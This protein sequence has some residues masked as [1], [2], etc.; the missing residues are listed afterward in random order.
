MKS[1]PNCITISRIFFSFLILF[2]RPL[3]TAFYLLY[4]ICGLTDVI[5]GFIA[6][7]TG[8]VSIL[9]AKLDSSAD[10]VMAAVLLVI[11]YPVL[12]PTTII[13]IWIII[14]GII[15]LTAMAVAFKKYKTFGSIHTYGNKI[16]GVILFLFPIFLFY[17]HTAVLMYLI[18]AVASISAIEEL[19]I[20]LA[21]KELQLDRKSLFIK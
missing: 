1:I 10:I 7:K 11:L 18:C 13:I 16:T 20:Q 3:S 21:S 8:T 14:I 19:I 2:T 12:N 15:R 4:V 9:G 6:R 17:I 5:D